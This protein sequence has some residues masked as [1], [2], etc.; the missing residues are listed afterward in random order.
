VRILFLDTTAEW[1]GRAGAFLA[2]GRALA[3]RGYDVTFACPP[4]PTLAARVRGAQ[5]VT[6]PSDGGDM[7][8]MYN[9]YAVVP[10]AIE[11][12]SGRQGFRP[13]FSAWRTPTV[14]KLRAAWQ[15]LLDRLDGSGVRGVV[16]AADGSV[17]MGATVEVAPASGSGSTD[18]QLRAVNADGSFHVVLFPGSYRVTVS[19]PPRASFI[20]EVTVAD[21]RVDL[22]VVID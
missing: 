13:T 5:L 20:R 9:A 8:W 15:M 3:A 10:F 17:P 4:A 22:D 12:N 2:A 11:L 7:D 18:V 14:A 19:A 6:V 16:H 1:F 21:V